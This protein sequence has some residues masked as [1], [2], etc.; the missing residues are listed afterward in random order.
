[1]YSMEI[2]A[3]RADTVI[4]ATG[5]PGIKR[6][7]NIGLVDKATWANQEAI[8]ARQ[9]RNMIIY[10]LVVT[11]AARM[12]DESRGAHYKREFPNRDD[13]RFMKVTVAEFDPVTE[14]PKIRYEDF[15]CSLVKPR[16]RNYAVA[17]KG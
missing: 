8:F 5:G 6:W 12:R 14:E 7:D 1:M 3:F 4:L 9:L 11:K 16:A 17:K 10:A 2:K 15:D 13:E